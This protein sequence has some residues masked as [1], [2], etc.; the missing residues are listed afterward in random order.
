MDMLSTPSGQP[1]A[2]DKVCKLKELETGIRSEPSRSAEERLKMMELLKKFE[3]DSAENELDDLNDGSDHEDEDDLARKLENIDLDLASTDELW[4]ILSPEQ[5]KRFAKA[6]QDPSS[7]LAQQLLASEAL[8]KELLR[9]WWEYTPRDDSDDP[10]GVGSLSRT[11]EYLPKPVA[12]PASMVTT[13]ADGPLLLYNLVAMIIAYAHCLRTLALPSF[14]SLQ[15]DDAIIQ[16]ARSIVSKIVPFTCDRQSKTL[17]PNIASVVT[18]AWSRFDEGEISPQF[19]AILLRDAARLL[20]PLPVTVVPQSQDPPT[21]VSTTSSFDYTPHPH[22]AAVLALSDLHRLFCAN[23]TNTSRSK[24]VTHKLVFYASRT[25][26]V[27]SSIMR[28]VVAEL[29]S[30]ARKMEV[31]AS[32]F[33]EEGIRT[34]E[35]RP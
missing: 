31:E 2:T 1:E 13:T 27:P 32:S 18:D 15:P 7:E 28:R 4:S 35:A 22:R 14:R 3:E 17:L 16:E 25:L 10:D 9:P 23:S 26:A 24:H 5:Q 33:V 11:N 8:E 20:R 29:V 30:E 12:V 6:M 19:F 21:D 34:S